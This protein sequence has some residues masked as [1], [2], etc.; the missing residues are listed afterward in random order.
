MAGGRP[1]KYSKQLGEVICNLLSD[2][3]SLRKICERPG[4]PNRETV[5]RWLIEHDEFS[6]HYA[7]AREE[8]AASLAD[9][10]LAI[11]D[12]KSG[13]ILDIPE[14]GDTRMI[15]NSAAVQRAKLQVDARKWY[16]SQVAPKR[17]G[18]QNIKQELTGKDGESLTVNL[19]IKELKTGG[20]D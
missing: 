12:D 8:Q 18:Q 1:T 15:T 9:E 3:E 20:D 17:W 7:R 13:D 10:C 5:R 6:G 11:A 16:A 19:I 2:G 14:G 4:M